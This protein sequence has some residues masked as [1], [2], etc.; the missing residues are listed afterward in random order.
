MKI[1]VSVNEIIKRLIGSPTEY[2]TSGVNDKKILLCNG[3]IIKFYYNYLEPRKFLY[4]QLLYDNYTRAYYIDFYKF[5][6][7]NSN[8]ECPPISLNNLKYDYIEDKKCI[9]S[10]NIDKC[11]DFPIEH[12]DLIRKYIDH[13]DMYEECMKLLQ[14]SKEQFYDKILELYKNN[15]IGFALKEIEYNNVDVNDPKL[16]IRVEYNITGFLLETFLKHFNLNN[17]LEE[18]AAD[19]RKHYLETNTS[20]QSSIQVKNE[21]LKNMIDVYYNYN[22]KPKHELMIFV[23][24]K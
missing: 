11:D 23:A 20:L 4:G 5:K 3:D 1:L 21:Q 15:L 18:V 9:T 14:E 13:K 12:H 2:L 8:K 22:A 16:K 24:E 19:V 10:I 7:I 6:K 17:I